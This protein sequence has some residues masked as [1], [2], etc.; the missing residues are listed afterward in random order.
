MVAAGPEHREARPALGGGADLPAARG[1]TND[2]VA[3]GQPQAGGAAAP[4]G[5]VEPV[6]DAVPLLLGDAGAAVA[7]REPD[8]VTLDI[9]ADR[10][11]PACRGVA[12]GVVEEDADQPVDPLR[13]RDH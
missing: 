5:A 2:R 1:L 3:D 12:A 9:D 7:D 11:R 4:D 6:E 10:H 13:W 8:P